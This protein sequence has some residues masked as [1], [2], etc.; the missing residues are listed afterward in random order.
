MSAK[1]SAV[2]YIA[3]YIHHEGML[4]AGPLFYHRS[5]SQIDP[6]TGSGSR[7]HGAGHGLTDVE[8]LARLVVAEM[9]AL[10][11]IADGK[12]A[13]S[14]HSGPLPFWQT[15][16]RPSSSKLPIGPAPLRR[17]MGSVLG[18]LSAPLACCGALPQPLTSQRRAFH[19]VP[20]RHLTPRL[21]Q[22]RHLYISRSS[23]HET[24]HLGLPQSKRHMGWHL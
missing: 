15:T 10:F 19:V 1:L 18:W 22:S 14:A 13:V 3:K 7:R 8:E 17:R 12:P 5:G 23:C 2:G 6:E 9:T 11:R 4:G 21:P 16:C 20:S 24:T